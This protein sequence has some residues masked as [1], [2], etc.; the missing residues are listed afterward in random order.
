MPKPW[1]GLN[2]VCVGTGN[3]ANVATIQGLQCLIANVFSIA[4]T[5][6]GLVGFVMLIVG[7]FRYLISGGNSKGTEAGRNTI[8]YAV[9]GLL[10][11]LSAFII[12]NLISNFTGVNTILNFNIPNSD[13]TF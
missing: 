8:T 7:A 12:L 6:I 5:L 1:T 2:S 9:I 11:A 13:E 3:A 10:V 4:I